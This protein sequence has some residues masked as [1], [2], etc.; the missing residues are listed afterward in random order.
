MAIDA[1]QPDFMAYTGGV[2][3]NAACASDKADLDHAVLAVGWGVD[4]TTGEEYVTVP[5]CPRRIHIT[6]TV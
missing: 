3:S 2:Y 5:T 4:A 6:S 1:S